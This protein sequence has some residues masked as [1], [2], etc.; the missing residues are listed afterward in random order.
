MANNSW[1]KASPDFKIKQPQ[2]YNFPFDV[3]PRHDDKRLCGLSFF[4]LVG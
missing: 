1:T 4:R 3:H 2:C